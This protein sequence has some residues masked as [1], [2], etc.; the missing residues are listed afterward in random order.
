MRPMESIDPTRSTNF[1]IFSRRYGPVSSSAMRA[2]AFAFAIGLAAV[3]CGSS[4]GDHDDST[5]M[6]SIDPS[7]NEL[8]IENGVFPTANYTAKLT[9]PNGDTRDVTSEVSF[10]IDSGYGGFAAST[11]T[12]TAAGKASVYATLV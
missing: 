6:L 1:D 11:L 10:A 2:I 8:L 12:M 3:A 4:G 5:A 7:T 9:Y